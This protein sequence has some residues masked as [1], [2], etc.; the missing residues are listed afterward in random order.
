MFSF[1]TNH[2]PQILLPVSLGA[3]HPVILFTGTDHN[4]KLLL[5]LVGTVILG[6]S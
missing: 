6:H 5:G 1:G 2:N 4:D 3:F